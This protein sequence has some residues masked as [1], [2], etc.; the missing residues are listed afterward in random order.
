MKN[1]IPLLKYAGNLGLIV[2]IARYAK[3]EYGKANGELGHYIA[4]F[5][6]RL[7]TQFTVTATFPVS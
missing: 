5:L 6:P 2:K 4:I 3:S 7:G 1:W